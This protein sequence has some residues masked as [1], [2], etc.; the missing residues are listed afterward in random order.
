MAASVRAVVT[1]IAALA[2]TGCSV[3]LGSPGG[4]TTGTG[5]NSS[6]TAA[7]V[8]HIEEEGRAV[9]DLRTP[10]TAT[11]LGAGD[12][13]VL[14]DV[15]VRGQDPIEVT[16]RGSR[17]DLVVPAD[18]IRVLVGADGS[19]VQSI[20][21]FEDQDD[22][23]ALTTRLKTVG[24]TVGVDGSA[25]DS[26]VASV[27]EGRQEVWLNGGESLGFTV[28]LHPVDEPD[29]EHVLEYQLTPPG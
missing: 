10:I 26:Y 25:L 3:S 9:I 20:A 29:G 14:R 15:D 28:G 27:G 5:D 17:G 22:T 12:G 11:D 23:A 13:Q 16:V 7:G 1:G 21:L 18:V 6:F 2:L 4:A 24:D 8:E 19:E